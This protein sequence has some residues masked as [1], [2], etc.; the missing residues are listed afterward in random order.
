M[1]STTGGERMAQRSTQQSIEE[2]RVPPTSL[3]GPTDTRGVWERL[4]AFTAAT[5]AT[6]PVDTRTGWERHAA[7]VATST[8]RSTGWPSIEEVERRLDDLEERSNEHNHPINSKEQNH[9]ASILVP[10]RSPVV[11]TPTCS[12]PAQTR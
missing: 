4:A 7:H 9:I 3:I 12:G 10:G 2:A 1:Q 11:T 5:S 8:A 6:G